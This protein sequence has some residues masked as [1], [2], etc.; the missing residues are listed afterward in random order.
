MTEVK[1]IPEDWKV[2]KTDLVI[3]PAKGD[4]YGSKLLTPYQVDNGKRKYRVY[5]IC[6]SNAAS[7]YVKVEGEVL[8]IQDY[9]FN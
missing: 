7:H 6:W 3:P 5:A 1:Y 8:F 9:R 2:I 4:G